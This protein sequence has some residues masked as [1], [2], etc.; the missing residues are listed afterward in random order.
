MDK[1]I[2]KFVI[3]KIE[4]RMN[5]TYKIIKFPTYFQHFS[6]FYTIIS[7]YFLTFIKF[8]IWIILYL[9]NSYVKI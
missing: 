4:N 3:L 6:L 8:I 9:L 1:N 5:T 7:Y 2:I